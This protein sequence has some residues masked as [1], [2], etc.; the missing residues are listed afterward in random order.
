MC[1]FENIFMEIFLDLGIFYELFAFYN[2]VA[3]NVYAFYNEV[4]LNVYEIENRGF[5]MEI[6]NVAS[7]GASKENKKVN[8]QQPLSNSEKR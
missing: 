1:L 8:K 3:Q 4:A 6:E 5:V 7:A 2:E